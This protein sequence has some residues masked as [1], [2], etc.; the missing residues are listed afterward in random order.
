MNSRIYSGKVAHVRLHPVVHRFQN[1]VHFYAL[2]LDELPALHRQV[3]GFAHN[4]FAPVSI[5]DRDYLTPEDRP[6]REKLQ[7]WLRDLRLETET[8]RITLVTSARWW[9]LVFNPV[10]FYLLDSPDGQ[11]L[12]MIAEVN[13]TFY[14]RHIYAVMLERGTGPAPAEGHDDKVFHV[15]P[16]N[17]MEGRYQF[18]L[19]RDAH[20]LYIGVNLY[21]DG[22]KIIETWIEGV[23]RELNSHSLLTEN[24]RHPLRA[25]LTF[26]RILWQALFLKFQHKLPHHRRPE[27]THPHTIL[28]KGKVERVGG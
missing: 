11:P 15:S 16:F 18:T 19:R 20:D 17:N 5:R 1:G 22:T 2:D 10:S 13:N 7:P 6:L 8:L 26:P 23:G 9:G 25:W 12:G 24:L 4:R 3:R 27:P 28:S 14:D 21:R